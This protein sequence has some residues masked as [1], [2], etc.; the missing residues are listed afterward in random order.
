MARP[1]RRPGAA[2]TRQTIVDAART[3]FSERGYEGA[4][5]R[6]I[7]R[8]AGVDPSLIYHYFP[9]GKADVFVASIGLPMDP[10]SVKQQ[11]QRRAKARPLGAQIVTGFLGLWEGRDTPRGKQFSAI[12]QAVAASE[13]AAR[14]LAEFLRDRVGAGRAPDDPSHGLVASQLVGLAFTR[15]VLGVEPIASASIEAV[16][17]MVG[18]T[19]DHYLG[20][21]P[22]PG[23]RQRPHRG[24]VYLAG[25]SGFFEAGRRWHETVVVPRVKAAGLVPVDPWA[26]S[27]AA[28]RAA[29]GRALAEVSLE[30]GALG[31]KNLRL[32]EGSE[33]I[34]ASLDGPDV[35]SGTALEIGYGF[36]RGLLVVGLRTD[37]RSGSD[38]VGTVVNSMVETCIADSGGILTASLDHAVDFLRTHLAP[39]RRS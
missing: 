1:G 24:R 19:I 36:C 32:L 17:E 16:A 12:V 30:P 10:R 27:A 3:E 11:A 29:T 25:P 21:A 34:L 9:T 8:R 26:S 23:Q 15:Y 20:T 35:D 7:A 5:V 14:S 39:R 28:G 33:A 18:P 38:G 13:A 37:A 31:S 4:S 2:P 6:A 22:P